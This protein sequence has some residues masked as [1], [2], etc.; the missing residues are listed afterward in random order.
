MSKNK[1]KESY[2]Q[3]IVKAIEEERNVR[4]DLGLVTSELI[5]ICCAFAFDSL[6]D[7]KGKENLVAQI[8]ACY[9]YAVNNPGF[10]E[11]E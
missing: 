9:I 2:I 6:G 7:E 3:T 1:K 11:R 8:E 10:R 4:N 5:Q